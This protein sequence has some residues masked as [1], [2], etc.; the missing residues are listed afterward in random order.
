MESIA[1]YAIGFLAQAFFS[2]RILFQWIL[3]EKAKHTVSPAIY[4]ILSLVGSY[5]LFVYGWLRNDFSIVMGQVISY[6]IYLWNLKE[7]GLWGKM[8]VVI[9]ALLILTPLIVVGYAIRHSDAFFSAFL[10]NKDI[11]LG[12]LLFGSAGQIIFT[13]RFVYQWI[14]S[15]RRHESLLPIGFWLISLVGSIVIVTYGIF[16]LDPVLILGQSCGLIAYVRN[17]MIGMK[18][19]KKI[20]YDKNK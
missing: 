6:F 3:S 4:W 20:L 7:K 9:R 16:R 12:L 11:P 2:A 5:L 19:K 18:A 13:L 17:I 1:I 15:S 8:N 14:Y 10:Q